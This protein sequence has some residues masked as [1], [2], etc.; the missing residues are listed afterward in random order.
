MID[1][2]PAPL[3]HIK[4]ILRFTISMAM[5]FRSFKNLRGNEVSLEAIGIL[6]KKYY[7]VRLL[8]ATISQ[9]NE[10]AILLICIRPIDETYFI[11]GARR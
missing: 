11:R 5:K 8:F 2:I 6:F 3:F 10:K 4:L 7:F 9:I 1:W